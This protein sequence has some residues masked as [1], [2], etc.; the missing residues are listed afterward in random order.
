[1]RG[2]KFWGHHGKKASR[3]LTT[4]PSN[5]GRTQD[6]PLPLNPYCVQKVNWAKFICQ[7]PSFGFGRIKVL[8]QE[9]VQNGAKTIGVLVPD[10]EIL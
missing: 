6:Y 8:H 1:M 4:F 3:S 2:K 10:S 7:R 5:R 9:I